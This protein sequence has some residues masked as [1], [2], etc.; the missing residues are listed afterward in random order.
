MGRLANMVEEAKR[1]A[2]EGATSSGAMEKGA[3][4]ARRFI[5]TRTRKGIDRHGNQF[6]PYAPSTARQKGRFSPVTLEETSQMLRSLSIRTNDDVDFDP[7][8]GPSGGGQFRNRGSGRF[9]ARNEVS[10]GATVNV[11]GSRNRKVGRA[12]IEAWGDLPER[13]WFGVTSNERTRITK[14]VGNR[15]TGGIRRE[16]PDD[17]RRR[18]EVQLF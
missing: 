11:K 5:R 4:M 9:V 10:F 2:L 12:H 1:R 8:A 7:S 17:R 15:V 18:V 16:L 14:A 13:D 6:A 3:R